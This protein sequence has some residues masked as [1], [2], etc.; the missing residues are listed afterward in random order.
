MADPNHE[1]LRQS[2]ATIF[3]SF[4]GWAQLLRQAAGSVASSG[5]GQP[6]HRASAAVRESEPP[7]AAPFRPTLRRPMAV[8]H[9]VDDGLESGETVR[10]RGDVLVIG[11]SEGDIV[12]PHDISM[13]TR[14]A[15]IERLPEGGWQLADLGSAGGTFVRVTTAKLK[16]GTVF[17]LGATRLRFE[18]AFGYATGAV[19]GP[20]DPRLLEVLPH[21]PGRSY[22][23]PGPLTTIGRVDGGCGIA[24]DDPFVSA[25]HATLHHT[26]RG[27]RIENSGANGL[28]VRI[29]AP[30][31]LTAPSQFQCGEQRFIFVPLL[32]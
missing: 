28:W 12:I 20:A 14:H 17:Q 16:H 1:P 5:D 10:M 9:V 7:D 24:I 13:S 6:Q 26:A 22:D 31:R 27:W 19:G 2:P 25:R 18:T 30:L 3:E 32:T 23:C 29:E 11:R 8:V 15:S 21:G 4:D